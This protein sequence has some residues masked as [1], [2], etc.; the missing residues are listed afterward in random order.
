MLF[1]KKKELKVLPKKESG[2]WTQELRIRYNA[3]MK[4]QI[5]EG[6]FPIDRQSWLNIHGN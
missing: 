5:A 6:K 2:Q 3:Y 4:K 1:G